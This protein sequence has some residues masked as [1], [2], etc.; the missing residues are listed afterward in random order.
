MRS[1]CHEC[2]RL[3][4]QIERLEDELAFYKR[5]TATLTE[6]ARNL[7]FGSTGLTRVIGRDKIDGTQHKGGERA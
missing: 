5:N 7:Y 3:T 1:K 6:L 4:A 2:D